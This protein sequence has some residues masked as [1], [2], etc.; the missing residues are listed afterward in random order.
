ML[1][2]PFVRERAAG[3]VLR[4]YAL[5]LGPVLAV[6]L[7]CVTLIEM[8]YR[9]STQPEAGPRMRLFWIG[10][11]TSTPWPWIG[12]GLLV[13]AGWLAWRWVSPRVAAAWSAASE[14]ANAG[15][16]HG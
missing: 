6:T 5:A 10:M 4:A 2:A 12:S 1:H 8:A 9:R 13:A 11:D 15:A 3:R 7:G 16:A 14:A